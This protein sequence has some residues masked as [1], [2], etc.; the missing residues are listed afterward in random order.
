MGTASL[1]LRKRAASSA[2]AADASTFLM[3]TERTWSAPFGGGGGEIRD[4]VED[5]NNPVGDVDVGD[6]DR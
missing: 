2:S 5:D 6:D 4:E 3:M 1:A